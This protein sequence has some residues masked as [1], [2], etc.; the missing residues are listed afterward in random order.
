MTL[1]II[2]R[3]V[4]ADADKPFGLRHYYVKPAMCVGA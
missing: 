2:A 4:A 3:D 1:A